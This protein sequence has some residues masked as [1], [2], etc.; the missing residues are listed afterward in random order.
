MRLRFAGRGACLTFRLKLRF[1]GNKLRCEA[2]RDVPA[3]SKTVALAKAA[4]RPVPALLHL[5]Q[6]PPYNVQFLG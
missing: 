1:E 3:A 6:H 2:R 5:Q 4:R